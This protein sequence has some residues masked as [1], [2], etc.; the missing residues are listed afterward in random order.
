MTIA[1]R[2]GEAHYGR[3]RRIEHG[4]LLEVPLSFLEPGRRYLAQVYRDGTDAHWRDAPFSF[5]RESVEVGSADILPL[6]LAA[7]GGQAI[8]FV[9]R[10]P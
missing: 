4:R 3:R 5:Q 2:M 1:Q 7:G 6:R 9:A 8:R 10:E